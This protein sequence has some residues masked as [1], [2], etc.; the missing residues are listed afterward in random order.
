MSAGEQDLSGFS[1]E[2][3]F[4]QEAAAQVELLTEG[5]LAMERGPADP[6]RMEALMRAAHS[7]KGAARIVGLQAAV[8]VAHALEDCFVAAQEGRL[9]ILPAQADLLLRAVDFLAH[10]ADQPGAEPPEAL[11]LALGSLRDAP[12]E[13]PPAP[14]AAAAAP[15]AADRP[16]P[17]GPAA[18]A[19]DQTVRVT[20]AHLSRMLAM[21]GESHVQ[22]RWIERFAE[23]L[24]ALDRRQA[25]LCG[26]LEALCLRGPDAGAA[27]ELL[28]D[29]EEVRQAAEGCRA[30]G[31]ERME[32]F[33]LWT[34]HRAE[35]AE[36]LY[37]TAIA[38]RMRPFADGVQGLPRM[39]RDLARELGKQARLQ[40]Q[41]LS[42]QV[43]RE[44]LERL[45]APLTHIL[46][47]ALDHGIEGP[48]ERGAAGKP[49]EGLLVVEASHRA[50]LLSVRVSDDGRGVDRD[51]L[52]RRI[53]ARGLGTPEM[54]A[55]LAESELFDFL[56][57]PGFSTAAQVTEIS[58]RGV[59]LDI[60]RTLVQDVGGSLWFESR[61][62]EGTRIQLELP[63]TLSVL[64]C[65]LLEVAGEPFA[66]PLTRIER[67]AR[68]G[69]D[70]G[71]RAEEPPSLSLDGRPVGLADAR[72]VLDLAPGAP[73]PALDRRPVVVL[74]DPAGPSG[75]VV[76][77]LLGEQKLP[78][79]PL[80]PH[81]GKVPGVSAVSVL[82]NGSPILILD[83]EDV[84]RLVQRT[85][86]AGESRAEPGTA[87]PD[88][89]R[90]R[91]RILV[92][93][94]SP[95]VREIE[96]RLLHDAGY[97]AEV[98]VDGV[99]GWNSLDAG[100][101]DLVVSDVDM[102]RMNGLELVRRIRQDPRFCALPVI[103]VSYKD[104]EEDRRRGLE[105]GA[106]AYLTKGS[107]QDASFLSA[108]T[109]LLAAG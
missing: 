45:E 7:I 9:T 98:A 24:L 100:G 99:D 16:P 25:E 30:L 95:T 14:P 10:A 80:D 53:V 6:T 58:G 76:D 67:L 15:A 50:G 46:R 11:V 18:E 23:S 5:L 39:V 107:F 103:V 51:A 47:N 55:G 84:A 63:A 104:R 74:A 48:E 54:A 4:R 65:L 31:R 60:V 61:P 22:A 102:P 1:M 52:R 96:R 82:E 70:A 43:D 35:A 77:R 88:R 56:F 91:R 66:L 97:A 29:L 87:A 27:P 3:L 2:E 81:L 13:P 75:L 36:R 38:S 34:G 12:A 37:R 109:H 8:A 26:L 78:V 49:P 108:V 32:E 19:A 71:A 59:G 69:P 101:Y 79:R 64:R 92:V 93:D 73:I 83:A 44:I 40:I 105:A 94:D 86:R 33:D 106:S 28:G 41:G 20:A 72:A 68:L 21:I 89:P 57:L 85:L 62:G 90:G 17:P 42:T